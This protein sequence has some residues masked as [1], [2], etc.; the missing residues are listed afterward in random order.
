MQ[1]SL[2]HKTIIRAVG[3]AEVVTVE[4]LMRLTGVS[5]VTI[6]RDLVELEGAGSLRRTHGGATRVLT[7]G[8]PMPFALRMTEDLDVKARLA[9]IAADLVADDESVIIDGGTTGA[10][11]AA[12]LAG[13]PVTALCLSLHAASALAS[14]PGA[15]VS[16]PGGPVATD[17]LEAEPASAITAIQ[18]V[19]VDVAIL[20]ACSSSAT[21]LT[22]VHS[23]DAQVKR[24][25]MTAA[26]R[27]ILVAA[28]TKLGR[29]ST[30]RFGEPA[31]LTHLVT[32]DDAPEE[33]LEAY[34]DAGVDVITRPA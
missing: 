18:G 6:R 2:R 15:M 27:R 4:A 23:A 14:R 13:R 11:V 25:A 32:T 17:S 34:R 5:A 21:A 22:T 30:F 9:V 31:D 10:A 28:G 20:G 29:S 12:E 8:T 7:R 16:V 24:A 26:T 3:Q 19:L 33:I 1:R